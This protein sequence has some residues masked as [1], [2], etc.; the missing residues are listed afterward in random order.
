MSRDI[1]NTRQSLTK[2]WLSKRMPTNETAVPKTISYPNLPLHDILK[3][4]SR[5]YPSRV[6]IACSSAKVS[7]EELASFSDH[8]A[9][10]LFTMG[11]RKGDRVALFLP[12]IPQ[13]VIAF[14]GIL[15]TGAIVTAIS[16][17]HRER[18]VQRQLSDSEAE[19]LHPIIESVWSET[20]LKRVIVTK[21]D[22]FA[23]FE[24]PAGRMS[25]KTK[26]HR[27]PELLLE[28]GN[29]P[30]KVEINPYEDLAALQYTGGTTGTAKGAML[31]HMNLISNALMF[32]TW[33]RG[34]EAEETF[35]T[36]L[37]LF[38]IYGLTTSLTVPVSLT[39]TMVLL[40]K[41]DSRAAL[42]SIQRHKVTVFCGVPTMY[43]TLLANPEIGNCDLAS[44]RLCISGASPLPAQVQEKFM[45][46]TGGFL[47]EGYGLTEASPVTHCNPVDRTLKTVRVGSIGL[48]LPDTEARIVDLEAGERTLMPSETG[49]LVVRG[50]QVMK[51]YWRQPEE[52]ASV[53]RNGWL[54]TGD[55]GRIDNDGYFYVTDRKKDLIKYKGYSVYPREIEDVLYE[56]PAVRLCAVVG[57]VFADV[58]EVPK[59]FVVL[60]EG[61][62]ATE[63]ELVEFVKQKIAPYKMLRQV[64]FKTELPISPAGKVL[65]RL[66]RDEEKVK[67]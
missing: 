66:L 10:A 50:P 37:P 24:A 18:E 12:N 29:S 47:A 17:L 16:P 51:G 33:I 5:L 36:A 25:L 62:S 7:Y 58:G 1:V 9:S 21:P 3:E 30:P 32:A 15:K 38:H 39:A 49:E 2:L 8:F 65:K 42:E 31:T 56:H 46:A 43:S 45:E 19:S 28:S 57:K 59:A 26:Y 44:L 55:I 40:P 6:A 64:E 53:L 23:D 22:E 60:K 20:K 63:A 27:F 61:T 52:T 34:V 54:H 35:L 14:Y 67:A 41:F 13:F 48:P 11:V 4:K